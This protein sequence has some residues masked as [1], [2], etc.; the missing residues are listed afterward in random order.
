MGKGDLYDTNL[1]RPGNR[2][3]YDRSLGRRTAKSEHFG[4]GGYGEQEMYEGS[5]GGR[6]EFYDLGLAPGGHTVKADIYQTYLSNGK[7]NTYQTSLGYYGNRKSYQSN[8]DY[9]NELVLGS[10]RRYF[11]EAEWVNNNNY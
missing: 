2:E 8:M 5:L 4:S 7:E 9:R 1:G 3:M 10:G 11:N 6:G